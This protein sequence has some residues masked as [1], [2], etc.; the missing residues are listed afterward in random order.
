MRLVFCIKKLAAITGGAEWVLASIS[1][2]LVARG[3]EVH[4]I[5][6]DHESET[7]FHP[8]SE[9]VHLHKIGQIEK[10]LFSEFKQYLNLRNLVLSLKPKIVFGF[11]PSIYVVLSLIFFL[12]NFRFVACEHISR[13]WYKGH[14]IKYALV[15]LA[16][17]ISDRITFLSADIAASFNHILPKKKLVMGNPVR[18]M[19]KLADVMGGRKKRYTILNVGRLVEFKD[20][21]TLIQAF[22]LIADAH[23]N[24]HLKIIGRGPLCSTIKAQIE[25]LK[26]A[27]K[28]QLQ[29]VAVD[30]EEEYANADLFVVSS[31]YEGY[32]LVTAEASSA[33][34]PCVGFA[35]CEGTNKIILDGVNGRLVTSSDDRCSS[36]AA[37]LNDLLGNKK[38]LRQMGQNGVNR[39]GDIELDV[40]L[41][42]WEETLNFLTEFQWANKS[43][44]AQQ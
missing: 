30:I 37:T 41:N 20:Q 36:L 23:P 42:K 34:L 19:T 27:N 4:I 7:S 5:T 1:S 40:V 10:S 3:H 43:E 26:L 8:I 14:I 13:E 15:C 22:S 18:K 11:L 29:D 2:G 6:F 33:G 35:D 32:G 9:H 24:W 28:V 31:F 39:P 17:N 44:K 21:K 38:I 12:N 16:G 25:H